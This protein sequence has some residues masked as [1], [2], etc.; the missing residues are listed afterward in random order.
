MA[1]AR[2]GAVEAVTLVDTTALLTSG[3]EGTGLTVLVDSLGDPV[4]AGITADGRVRGVDEDDLEVLVGGVLVNPVGV[5]DTQV[6]A[7]TADLLLSNGTVGALVLELVDTLVGGLTVGGTLVSVTLAATATDTDTVDHVALLGLV[8]E[9]T[10][11]VGAARTASTVDSGELAVL[12]AADTQKETK[13]V[14]LLVASDLFQ[15]LVGT[16]FRICVWSTLK[17]SEIF[18]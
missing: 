8:A 2:L 1:T 16:H 13:D 5:E 10:S 9:T 12:P 3:G 14:R 7:T 17:L 4:D 6:T 11:L 18:G 15:V